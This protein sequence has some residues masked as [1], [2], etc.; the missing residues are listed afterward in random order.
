MVNNH[1]S[2][3]SRGIKH[4]LKPLVSYISFFW[5]L[6]TS[7]GKEPEK[8]GW[9]SKKEISTSYFLSLFLA[10]H[11]HLGKGPIVFNEISASAT[12]GN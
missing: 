4:A 6:G 1:Y 2:L 8:A 11:L 9:N 12:Y 5:Y 10:N 7:W 3:A